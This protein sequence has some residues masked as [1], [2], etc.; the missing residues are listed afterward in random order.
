MKDHES[1]QINLFFLE[2][3]V[4]STTIFNNLY[5]STFFLTSTTRQKLNDFAFVLTI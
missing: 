5:V 2:R 1:K 4:V 3:M